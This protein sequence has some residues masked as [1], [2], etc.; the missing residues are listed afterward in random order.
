MGFVKL[1]SSLTS[2][3]LIRLLLQG[4]Q[5]DQALVGLETLGGWVGGV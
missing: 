3:P 1:M 2:S 4:H 5:D